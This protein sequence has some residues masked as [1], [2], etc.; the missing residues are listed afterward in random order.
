MVE[1]CRFVRSQVRPKRHCRI[2]QRLGDQ[3]ENLRKLG[4]CVIE[5]G[6]DFDVALVRS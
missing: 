6:A 4:M 1:G 2:R 5:Y 3:P